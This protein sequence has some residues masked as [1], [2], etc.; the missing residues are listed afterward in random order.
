MPQLIASVEGVEIRKVDLHKST[1][2]LGRRKDNDIVFKNLAVSGHHCVFQREGPDEFFVEDLSSTNGTFVNN[3]RVQRH[4]LKEGDLVAVADIE[5]AFVVAP[6]EDESRTTTTTAQ[7]P[8]E[9]QD[10]AGTA[11]G[12]C[13]SFRFISGPSAGCDV[14]IQKSVTTFG[15]PGIAVAVVS[16]RRTGYFVACM[17]ASTVRPLLNGAPMGF[18]AAPLNDKDVVEVAGSVVRFCART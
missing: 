4:R 15:T 17:D 13:A 8:V 9:A 18:D 11:T 14:P 10:A 3:R 2:T 6:A 16:H 1:S 7:V 12:G 5:L